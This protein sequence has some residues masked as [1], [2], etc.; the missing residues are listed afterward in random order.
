MDDEI[1]AP[2]DDLEAVDEEDDDAT[3]GDAMG[4][5]TSC[6]TAQS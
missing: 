1:E 2:L 5:Q 6:T 3:L 4:S